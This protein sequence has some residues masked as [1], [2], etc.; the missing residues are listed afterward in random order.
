MMLEKYEAL[1]HPYPSTVAKIEKFWYDPKQLHHIERL[2]KL[3]WRYKDGDFPNFIHTGHEKGMLLSVKRWEMK[4]SR[5]DKHAEELL[6]W[7]K[8][9]RDGYT[10]LPRFDA[11]NA[12][13]ELSYS[14]IKQHLWSL[15]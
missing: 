5:V 11:K 13:I 1:R 3:M 15:K 6:K 8:A 12:I 4:D 10:V 14:I 7:A 9:I 2:I